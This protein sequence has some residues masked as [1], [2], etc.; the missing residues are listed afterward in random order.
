MDDRHGQYCLCHHTQ[1]DSVDHPALEW[2]VGVD[3]QGRK[4]V[5]IYYRGLEFLHL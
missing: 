4:T 3:Q 2:V 1:T 5:S